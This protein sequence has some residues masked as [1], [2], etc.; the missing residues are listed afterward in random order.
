MVISVRLRAPCGDETG[1]NWPKFPA[2][3]ADIFRS[4]DSAVS[5]R[6]TGPRPKIRFALDSLVEQRRFEPSVPPGWVALI[7]TCRR[8]GKIL[9]ISSHNVEDREGFEPSV[10]RLG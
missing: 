4:F 3:E 8:I 6:S 5:N 9:V 10:P 2:Q 7:A 1:L